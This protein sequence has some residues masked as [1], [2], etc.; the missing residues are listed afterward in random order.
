MELDIIR[1]TDPMVAEYIEKELKR[2]P[3][4]AYLNRREVYLTSLDCKRI[5]KIGNASEIRKN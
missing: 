3:L 1:Q 4:T 5:I 2:Q